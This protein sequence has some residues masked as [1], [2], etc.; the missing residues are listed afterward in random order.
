MCSQILGIRSSSWPG[1]FA[2][3]LEP[4][5]QV[6][7]IVAMH[8]NWP[9]FLPPGIYPD[10]ELCGECYDSWAL[11]IDEIGQAIELQYQMALEIWKHYGEARDY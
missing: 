10:C 8:G 3:V 7:G 11:K 4:K 2:A 9:P 6:V 1:H 5:A